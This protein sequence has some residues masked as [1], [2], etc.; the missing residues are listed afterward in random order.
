MNRCEKFVS[1]DKQRSF[2]VNIQEAKEEILHTVTAY[3]SKDEFGRYEIPQNK[4]RPIFLIGPPGIGKTEI[5][6]Q[7][8]SELGIGMLSYSM[9]HHTRQ[10]ALGLPLIKQKEYG[11]VTYDISE[12]TM[13]EIIASVYEMM[14]RTGLQNGLLFLDEINCVS[15]T[16][17]P[18]M[19][20]FLQY[21]VFGAHK[22]PPGWVVV[23][24]GNPP[25]YNNSVHEFDIV[26]WDRLKRIDVEP[27]LSVWKSYASGIGVHAAI[28]TYLE[29]KPQNFYQIETTVG[30]KQFVTARG[31]DDLSRV[32]RQYE[33]HN[34]PV[35][36]NLIG[37]YLQHEK[38][39]K[40]FAIYYDLFNK[41]KSDYQVSE[42]LR[43]S[44]S[45]EIVER[46]RRAKF[47]ERY[48]LLGLLLEVLNR[49]SKNV[50]V[51]EELFSEM[52]KRLKEIKNASEPLT[53]ALQNAA[54]ALKAE[55]K[56]LEDAN[57]L[58]ANQ[59][60]FY[61][62]RI[63]LLKKYREAAA[64]GGEKPFEAV[65]A[66]FSK[67]VAEYQKI[68]ENAK[69][70]YKSA[71]D[72]CDMAFGADGQELLIL[73]TEIASNPYGSQY[74]SKKGCAEYFAHD[75]E[76]MFRERNLEIISELEQLDFSI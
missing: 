28:T 67:D 64:R 34:L 29:I 9:T 5:M 65:R 26:T 46:A 19:L 38:I 50:M 40:D 75:K 42:I 4:Q 45:E 3:L 30:G 70:H 31:W 48:S 8:A 72:F 55:E 60:D 44:F 1:F 56:K 35:T 57:A 32:I 36:R 23:T 6:A 52:Q 22:V 73:V 47:D 14:E 76:L 16:L 37:Q 24:A 49:D 2:C 18:I 12:Y 13:S 51:G 25:E 54:D 7:V 59:G 71:F 69:V 63:K 66:V 74:V 17:T 10:S 21:K 62:T 61:M 41:Y 33:K 68:C 39:A 53:T 11:G 58:S 43:G 20:Q 15:E 27:D